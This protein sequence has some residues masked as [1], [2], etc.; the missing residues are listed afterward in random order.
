MPPNYRAL[1]WKFQIGNVLKIN[2]PLYQVLM[3][4][5][6]VQ[7]SHN[8]CIVRDIDRTFLHLLK[9]KDFVRVLAEASLLLHVF[10][11]G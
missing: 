3:N 11:V 2:K 9:S 4:Q 7:I 1:V 10:S 8:T 6:I 5:A